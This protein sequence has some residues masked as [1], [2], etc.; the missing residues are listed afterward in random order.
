MFVKQLINFLKSP[1][2]VIIM[3]FFWGLALATFFKR[4]CKS[5][6]CQSIQYRVPT[7][8]DGKIFYLGPE[9][10]EVCYRYKAYAVQCPTINS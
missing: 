6:N 9:K 3:S 5:A 7:D 2:G 1:L 4:A 8:V 10:Q